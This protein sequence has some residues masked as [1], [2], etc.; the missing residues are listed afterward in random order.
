[1]DDAW[2]AVFRDPRR[3]GAREAA[4]ALGLAPPAELILSTRDTALTMGLTPPPGFRRGGSASA[5][6][7]QVAQTLR[8]WT[9][10]PE[11]VTA[12]CCFNDLFAGLVIAA[13][14]SIGLAVPGD[15]SVIGV[16]D[17]PLSGLLQPALTTVRYD[18][19]ET[20][21]HIEARLRA[22]LDGRPAPPPLSSDAIGL[23]ERESVAP[24]AQSDEISLRN[25]LTAAG[26]IRSGARG[27]TG[28]GLVRQ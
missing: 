26:S 25:R 7:R 19:R 13:A 11:P 5:P 2:V 18:F 1:V 9:A 24:L 23:I 14:R 22:A 21:A 3:E 8:A 17:E 27:L 15:L 12:I 28:G 10:T 6:V 20:T 16:D 4:A